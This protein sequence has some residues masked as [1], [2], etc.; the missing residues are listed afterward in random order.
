MRFGKTK[1]FLYFNG[2]IACLLLLY[3]LPWVFSSTTQAK[4]ISPYYTNTL[5]VEYD[6]EGKQFNGDYLRNDVDYNERWVKVRYL[7]FDPS[8]SR[9]NSFMGMF[10]EPLA[11]W[12]VFLAASSMLLLTNNLVFSKGTVFQVQGKFPWIWMEEYFPV[13][14][15]FWKRRQRSSSVDPNQA[16]KGSK[17]LLK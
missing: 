1:M 15:S 5:H 12:S 16:K 3:F 8:S 14:N 13:K 9:V 10:A 7:R 17:K 4:V 11:W 6:A 2:V